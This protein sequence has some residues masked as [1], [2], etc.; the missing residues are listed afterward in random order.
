MTETDP[1]ETAR[2]AAKYYE[3]TLPAGQRKELGQFFTGLRLGK[4]LAHLALESSTKTVLDPM[5][6]HGDLL[7]ATQEAAIERGI[8]TVQRQ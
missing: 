5:A 3:Q 7:D 8:V 2:A 4:L 6:G 1:R